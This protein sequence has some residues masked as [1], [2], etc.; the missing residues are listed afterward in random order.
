MHAAPTRLVLCTALLF[1]SASPHALLSEAHAQQPPRQC[2]RPLL[3]AHPPVAATQDNAGVHV[4]DFQVS[5]GQ[6]AAYRNSLRRLATGHGVKVAVIDTGVAAHPQLPRLSAGPDFLDPEHPNSLDDCDVHG[7]VVA[8]VIASA[9]IG[10]APEAE[11]FSI[12]Q[13][14]NLPQAAH[15]AGGNLETLARAIH[16]AVDAGAQ[17]INTS[18]VSCLS[19]PQAAGL[20]TTPLE[21]ALRR[22]EDSGVLVVSAAGNAGPTCPADSVV[23]PAS[24]PTVLSVGAVVSPGTHADYSLD[25]QL[26]APGTVPIGLSPA[27]WATGLEHQ[28]QF[29]GTS[30]ATPYVSATAALLKQRHPDATP[31]HLRAWLKAAAQPSG[32]VDPAFALQAAELDGALAPAPTK[33]AAIALAP[34]SRPPLDA[35]GLNAAFV[36]AAV[37]GSLLVGNGFRR[38]R[39]RQR[40]SRSPR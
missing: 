11:I 14:T 13:S 36:I 38:S 20:D 29:S 37:A 33:H 24:A 1:W 4:P 21:D 15:Q 2:A 40:Q 9:D 30:F 23:F 22:A 26:L 16:A 18:V 39:S 17:V 7:T 3:S 10:I 32:F 27:G 8:G 28:P 19:P 25:A 35:R 12:K 5:P 6:A 34:L 31:E